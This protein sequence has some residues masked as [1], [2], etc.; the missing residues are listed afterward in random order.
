M[1]EISA[2]P[3]YN[4]LLSDR[5][6]WEYA[7]TLKIARTMLENGIEPR[8]VMKMTGLTEDEIQQLRH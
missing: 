3:A 8:S 7:A 5:H 1:T 4:P 2:V 6:A